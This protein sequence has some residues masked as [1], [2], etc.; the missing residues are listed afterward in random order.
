MAKARLF[1]ACA[2]KPE[3]C[4]GYIGF[5][6]PL[7]ALHLPHSRLLVPRCACRRNWLHNRRLKLIELGGCRMRRN[8]RRQ[9]SRPQHPWLPQLPHWRP[10]SRQAQLCGPARSQ[11]RATSILG[12]PW[13]RHVRALQQAACRAA[14]ACSGALP[15]ACYTHS[16][17]IPPASLHAGCIPTQQP[18]KGNSCI[19]DPGMGGP[20]CPDM[21]PVQ[22]PHCWSTAQLPC[23]QR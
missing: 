19:D 17:A 12:P 10:R 23:S 5:L 3:T 14:Q 2:L 20:P 6:P 1:Q 8:L 15:V 7:V 11:W 13:F 22:V 4:C 9:H 21:T 18:A 16:A